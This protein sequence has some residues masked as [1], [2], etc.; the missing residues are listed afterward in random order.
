MKQLS[1]E[2]FKAR[3]NKITGSKAGA[4]LGMS[5]FANKHDVMLEMLGYKKFEGNAATEYGSF[6][7]EYALTDFITEMGVNVEECGF[8][9][10][11]DHNWLGASPDGLVG[12]NA[13]LEIKCPYGLRESQSPEFKSIDQLDHYYAQLQLEMACTGRDTAYFY[14]WNRYKSMLEIVNFDPEWH[15]ENIPLL[16]EFYDDF[17]RR[18]EQTMDDL[19][20][21]Y[22]AA[23]LAFDEAKDAFEQVKQQVIDVGRDTVGCLKVVTV[24]RKGAIDYKKVPELEGVDLEPYR[25]KSTEF[26]KIT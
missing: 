25:K 12:D 2:W 26:I 14:Q 10:H 9:Q 3:E 6:H 18:K 19:S 15:E 17:L 8:I 22:H 20:S 7:E 16:R 23:K 1:N 4:I 21:K 24:E 5:P 11:P 13:I